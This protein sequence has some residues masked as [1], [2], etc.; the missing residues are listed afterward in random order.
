M[1]VLYGFKIVRP[2]FESTQEA[3]FEWLAL[4]HTQAE[5]K[6]CAQ[7]KMGF[8]PKP[9]EDTL[10]KALK[11]YGC[12]SGHIARR[13]H[14]L[15][16]YGVADPSAWKVFGPEAPPEGL[17]VEA[18]T[19]VFEKAVDDAFG[20]LYE[21]VQTPP[22]Q[23]I[24]VTCTGYISPSGAQKL[25]SRKNW[26]KQTNVMHAY[27]MGC[28]A[29]IPALR[30]ARGLLA[31]EAMRCV[32]VIHTELCTLHLNPALHT[33]EQLVVQS[34]FADGMIRYSMADDAVLTTEPTL[35]ILALTEEIAPASLD[36]MQWRSANWGMRMVLSVEIPKLIAERIGGFVEELCAKAGVSHESSTTVYAIHPGG[37]K[38]LDLLQEK[39]KLDFQ[40]LRFSRAVLRDYGNMSS[41]TLPHIWAG[42]LKDPSVPPGTPIVS[43]AFGPGLSICGALLR[44][45]S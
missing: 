8:E 2:E 1:H 20:L 22:P 21:D 29:A 36:A 31:A 6:R 19:A 18:R 37:P 25:I 45:R 23:I 17:G 34:L 16:E 24:H 44:K 11:R 30:M 7:E 10:R 32:D 5:A 39:L 42:I 26:H 38:I 13:G 14:V 27:H 28:S 41:A 15:R 4:A 9:F 12:G 3:A 43:L 40:A 35:E 33:P